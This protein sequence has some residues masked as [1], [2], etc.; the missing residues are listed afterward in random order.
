MSD[1][2]TSTLPSVLAMIVVLPEDDGPNSF[3]RSTRI[4][5]TVPS[6]RMSTF[7]T[8]APPVYVT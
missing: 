3:V 4:V 7:F 1:P 6:T 2:G 5:R 8:R